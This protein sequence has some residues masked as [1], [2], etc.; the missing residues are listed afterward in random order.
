[1]ADP[2]VV[3]CPS[4]LVL[5]IPMPHKHNADRRHHIPKM[6]FKVQNWPA[7]EA[8]LRRR[9]SLTLGRAGSL[10]RRGHPDQPD[11]AHG[12][13]AGI[14]A[15]RGP[16]DIRVHVAGPD[17]LSAGSQH[18]Q[19]PDG[20]IAG[21]PDNVDAARSAARIDRQHGPAGLRSGSMAGG[22]A[23]RKVASDVA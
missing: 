1:M 2:G 14:A 17:A 16:D 19:P 20:D 12:V 10:Y 15:D 5:I 9:G 18:A 6:A 4:S 7:Y 23:W 22:E 11:A 8:G 3:G 13:Q 21:D